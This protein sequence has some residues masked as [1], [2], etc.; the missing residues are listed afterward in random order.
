MFEFVLHYL[1][2]RKLYNDWD[3]YKFS[4]ILKIAI[5]MRPTHQVVKSTEIE[6]SLKV[7]KQKGNSK[8]LSHCVEQV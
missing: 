5:K 8:N 1:V 3:P 7:K 6:Y 4:L 2:V